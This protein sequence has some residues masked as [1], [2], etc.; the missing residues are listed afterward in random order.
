MGRLG[1]D[2]WLLNPAFGGLY[3][4]QLQLFPDGHPATPRF[5]RLLH[6]SIGT[7]VVGSIIQPIS[8]DTLDVTLQG[9]R[10][11]RRPSARVGD[12][13]DDRG[14]RDRPGAVGRLDRRPV[15]ARVRAWSACS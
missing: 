2:M 8:G 13:T 15:P 4:L 7:I 1:L 11:P 9:R 5:R 3:L 6:W 12:R 14:L 10:E